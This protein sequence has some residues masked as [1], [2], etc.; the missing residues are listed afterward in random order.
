[1]RDSWLQNAEK[2]ED[3]PLWKSWEMESARLECSEEGAAQSRRAKSSWTL[4]SCGSP[5]AFEYYIRDLTAY[6]TW[7]FYGKMEELV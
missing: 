3:F 4:L 1:V 6:A 2:I 5:V 7:V